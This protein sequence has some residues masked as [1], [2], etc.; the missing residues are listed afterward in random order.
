M[1]KEEFNSRITELISGDYTSS[2]QINN[3][4]E[5]I[6]NL[7]K[8]QYDKEIDVEQLR[9]SL[10]EISYRNTY[11]LNNAGIK[12]DSAMRQKKNKVLDIV[13]YLDGICF[14]KEEKKIG[15]AEEEIDQIFDGSELEEDDIS[16][17]EVVD[18][19]DEVTPVVEDD[20]DDDIF[21]PRDDFSNSLDTRL[22]DE[23]RTSNKTFDGDLNNYYSSNYTDFVPSSREYDSQSLQDATVRIKDLCNKLIEC[24]TRKA[25][26][27]KAINDVDSIAERRKRAAIV[28]I[29]QE[30]NRKRA[31]YQRQLSRLE[32]SIEDIKR[33]L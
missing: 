19:G 3:I 11:L 10:L 18:N 21:L 2:E 32:N 7:V 4:I 26:L 16:P 30:A 24:N 22:F 9:E 15:K 5:E 17:V 14:G 13:N 28:Q 27:I 33:A 1:N 8:E 31:E 12:V 20:K 25:E 6:K 23:D 29:E